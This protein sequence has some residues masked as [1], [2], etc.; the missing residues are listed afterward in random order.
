MFV[1]H[2]PEII[3]ILVLALFFLGPKRLPEA[4]E[5]LGKA[6]RGFKGGLAGQEQGEEGQRALGAPHDHVEAGEVAPAPDPLNDP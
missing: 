2:L 4:G 5:S 6:I 3:I 1:D